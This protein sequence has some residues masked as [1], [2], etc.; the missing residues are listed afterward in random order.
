[1]TGTRADKRRVR[2]FR[3]EKITA[4]VE[5]G[6]MRVQKPGRIK[7]RKSSIGKRRRVPRYGWYD[8][9]DGPFV[10]FND[11]NSE[12]LRRALFDDSAAAERKKR[13]NTVRRA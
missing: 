11:N 1:M 7:R 9:R 4:R 10:T 3:P 12:R 5:G 13:N 6:G 2:Y 8:K